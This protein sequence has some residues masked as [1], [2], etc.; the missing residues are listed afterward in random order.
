[1][2]IF[3]SDDNLVIQNNDKKSVFFNTETNN[4]SID[5][6][7]TTHPWEYEK[8]GILLEVKE[9]NGVLFY[10]FLMNS[11]HVSIITIDNFEIK[12]DILSFFWD[13]DLLIIIWNKQSVKI[14]ETIEAKVV[15]PYWEWKDLFLSTLW[16]NIEETT[17]YKIK[18][19]TIWDISVFVNLS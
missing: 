14:Y 2:E 13:L 19:D 9:Y 3:Y 16:Q 7:N 1:M 4:V 10:K 5:G 8:S 15:V 18:W 6:F 12:E 11:K 17:N